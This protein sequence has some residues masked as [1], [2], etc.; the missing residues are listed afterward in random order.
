MAALVTVRRVPVFFFQAEGGIR[1]YKV[2][3]VQTC[4]LPI[5]ARPDRSRR[6]ARPRPAGWAAIPACAR[7]C[8]RGRGKTN[9]KTQPW[10]E[11]GKEGCWLAADLSAECSCETIAPPCV[12]VPAGFP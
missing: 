8:G 4:A 6:P 9:A 7:D 3:G 12:I 1:D 2:T 11:S 5:W 10:R